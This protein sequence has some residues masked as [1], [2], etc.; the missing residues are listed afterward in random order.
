MPLSQ[1]TGPYAGPIM[2]RAAIMLLTRS[3]EGGKKRPR[4]A[5]LK[6]ILESRRRK[7][8]T[9]VQGTIRDVRTDGDTDRDVLDSA[10]SSEVAIQ[11]EIGFVLM[12]MKAETLSQIETA[13]RRISEGTYGHCFDCG[14]E[15]AEARLRALPFALRCRDCEDAREAGQ[16]ERIMAQRRSSSTFFANTHP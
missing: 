9:E 7:L 10:E 8:A 5:E 2:G 4:R 12:E 16:R 3:A 15:I 6:T 1:T 11:H 14:G 13:L